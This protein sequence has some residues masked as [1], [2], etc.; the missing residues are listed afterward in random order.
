MSEHARRSDALTPELGALVRLAAA[1]SS[2]SQSLLAEAM[3]DAAEL[4]SRVG[5][6][7]VLLQGYLFVGY[8]AT[9]RAFALWRT[10]A[11][12]TAAAVAPEE[13]RADWAERGAEVC[14]RIYGGAYERLRENV[15]A[16]HPDLERWRVEE[17]YGKV[18]GRP[19]LELKD[20]E[21]CIVALLAGLPA[22][23]QLHSH[24]RGALNAGAMPE[25]VD[26]ALE[27]AGAMLRPERLAAARQLWDEVYARWLERAA[28]LPVAPTES[29]EGRGGV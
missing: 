16:L 25:Q 24:L 20:R 2:P 6:E 1:M 12:G 13:S 7:E 21:L 14:A 28:G 22:P 3:H 10:I 18:L 29:L 26:A 5:A 23:H 15:A 9:L 19:G 17:G 11:G 8:P 4:A 27:H